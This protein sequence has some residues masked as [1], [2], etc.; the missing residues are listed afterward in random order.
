[1]WPEVLSHS[2]DRHVH[3]TG[4]HSTPALAQARPTMSC[5]LWYYK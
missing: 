2:D 3:A 1:V 4:P 5:I